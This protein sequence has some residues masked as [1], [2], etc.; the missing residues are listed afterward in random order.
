MGIQW[1][2]NILL[3]EP[4]SHGG[5]CRERNVSMVM[6]KCNMKAY[7]FT[8]PSYTIECFVMLWTVTNYQC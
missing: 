2:T 4:G 3:I 5:D 1:K 8:P 7:I 6:L